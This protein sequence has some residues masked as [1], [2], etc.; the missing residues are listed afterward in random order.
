[1]IS[2]FFIYLF[3]S[4]QSEQNLRKNIYDNDE[5]DVFNKNE[6]DLSKIYLGKK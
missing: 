6:V 4:N 5:F 2:L 1:M 3:R